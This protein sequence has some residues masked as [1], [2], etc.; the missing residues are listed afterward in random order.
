MILEEHVGAPA[1]PP[2]AE[3][4]A[5]ALGCMARGTG[6]RLIWTDRVLGGPFSATSSPHC[7]R[8]QAH[9]EA[10][11]SGWKPRSCRNCTSDQACTSAEAHT[12]VAVP[13]TPDMQQSGGRHKFIQQGSLMKPCFA[14]LPVHTFGCWSDALQLMLLM[15]WSASRARFAWLI[16]RL[17]S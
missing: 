6:V 4:W 12:P 16:V 15:P 13:L 9:R 10:A 1:F 5:P 3:T 7:P 2:A 8:H 14:F 11:T 17:P